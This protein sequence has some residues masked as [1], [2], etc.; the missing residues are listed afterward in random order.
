MMK[1]LFLTTALCFLPLTAALAE[2]G[3]TFDLQVKTTDAKNKVT[4]AR[5]RVQTVGSRARVDVLES[6]GKGSEAEMMPG[7]FMVTLDEG[8]STT[9]FYN[10]KKTMAQTGFASSAREINKEKALSASGL[11]STWSSPAP[12]QKT[13][14]RSFKMVYRQLVFKQNIS[15]DENYSFTLA[16]PS[17]AGPKFNPLVSSMLMDMGTYALKFPEVQKAGPVGL[18]PGGFVTKATLNLKALVGK[19]NEGAIVEIE[20]T[21]PVATE[22]PESM[23]E[24]PKGY[25]IGK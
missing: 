21:T 8:F 24:L 4:T 22:I 10:Q 16:D 23:F 9:W 13:L 14:T 3:Y 1:N 20:A 19:K 6:S 17:V 11:S 7:D 12:N 25:K 2:T 5:M 18:V 15:I